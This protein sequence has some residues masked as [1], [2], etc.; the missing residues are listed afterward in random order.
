MFTITDTL[1][2]LISAVAFVNLLRMATPGQPGDWSG[3]QIRNPLM[4]NIYY[5]ML[6]D[7]RHREDTHSYWYEFDISAL[8]ED[9]R[10]KFIGFH[11][12]L[13]T[14]QFLES[15][16]EKAE[17][18]FT[19]LRHS[20][21]RYI[22]SWF[23]TSTSI[24]GWLKRGSMFIFSKGQL[25]ALLD[26]PTGWHWQAENMLDLG[27]G[28]GMVTSQLAR[29]F[30]NVYATEISEI[31]VKRLQE[32]GYRVLG[33]SEWSNGTRVYDIISCLNLLDRC[34]RPISIL[35]SIRQSLRRGS[36]RAIVAV[37]LPFKPFVE[38]GSTDH[39][40]IEC[41]HI[42]GKTFEEQTVSLIR[43]VFTPAGFTVEK[44]SKLPYLCEGDINKSFFVLYDAV[45]VL[46]ATD[47]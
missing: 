45:F 14:T 28:D 11:Q 34:D 18:I 17:W 19:Q 20:L 40:P 30:D 7:Q 46:R 39:Q 6:E 35:H 22:L 21:L 16:Y 4:R 25:D 32:R 36:G 42:E 24:N 5:R 41:L 2:C 27:A 33:I 13:E 38:F 15:C 8:P 29:Y 31:M 9:L 47:V 37:V 26:I 1:I 43:H 12:D 10:D 44:F 3:Q 23:M